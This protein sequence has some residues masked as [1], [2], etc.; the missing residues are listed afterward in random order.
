MAYNCFS[1]GLG[2]VHSIFWLGEAADRGGD[3]KDEKTGVG[4]CE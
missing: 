1:S 2:A 3:E 4:A